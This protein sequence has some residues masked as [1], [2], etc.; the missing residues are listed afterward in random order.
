ME[1][2]HESGYFQQDDQ[3]VSNICTLDKVK[4]D[5]FL[6]RKLC[7]LDKGQYLPMVE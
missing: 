5:D 3:H 1:A 6:C 2:K 4:N 7:M